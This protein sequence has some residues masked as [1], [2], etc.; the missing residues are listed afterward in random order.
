MKFFFLFVF[1]CQLMTFSFAQVA[2]SMIMKTD[3]K[4]VID[5]GGKKRKGIL[6]RVK[7][8]EKIAALADSAKAMS[9]D[10][11]AI[12][13]ESKKKRAEPKNTFYGIK[14]KKHFKKW[15]EGRKVMMEIFYYLPIYE[16]HGIYSEEKDYYDTE[17]H[18]IEGGVPKVKE[19]AWTLHGPY[20]RS[21]DGQTIEKGI[22][23]MG[24]KHGRWEKYSKTGYLISKEIFYRG[25]PKESKF[26]YHDE[27]QKRLKEIIPYKEGLLDGYY[28]RTYKSGVIAETGHYRYGAKVGQWIEYFDK[29]STANHLR[30]TQ[31]SKDPFDKSVKP[32][33]KKE[34]NEKGKLIIDAK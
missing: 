20:E 22:Y 18:K 14:T 12:A 13:L 33:V 29:K 2:D 3:I 6:G 1:F 32:F 24:L 25:F 30:I 28:V 16:E 21:E 19:N 11:N 10:L 4:P 23:Y 5:L 31:H 9:A 27:A 34:W 26:V 17:K 15:D 7:G 8:L